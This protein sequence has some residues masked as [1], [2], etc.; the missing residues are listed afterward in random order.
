MS[1][2]LVT[3]SQEDLPLL[4]RLLG[5]PAM[6]EH[7]GGP[8]TAEQIVKRHERYVGY[9][10]TGTLAWMFKIVRGPEAVGSIG[11]W[12]KIWRDEPVY[13]MGWSILP[14]YQGQG[15]ATEATLLTVARA[16]E[17][18][19]RR[20]MHAFPSVDNPPSNAICH[21]AGFTLLGPCEFEY[22]PGHAL[23]VN[24]W[25]LALTGSHMRQRI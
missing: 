14:A 9:S 17:R 18:R 19:E 1:L 13:E 11:F 2:E 23:R 4:Q 22:P 6:T 3:W 20:H 15:I 7:I 21:K 25:R 24:D 5:D 16:R 10:R 12:E 8:E